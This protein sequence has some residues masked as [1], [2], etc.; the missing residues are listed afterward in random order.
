[1]PF[2]PCAVASM[3]DKLKSAE[4]V[5]K[6]DL[7]SEH[8][9][10]TFKPGFGGPFL[11]DQR[12]DLTGWY[13]PDEGYFWIMQTLVSTPEGSD[14]DGLPS[15]MA[16]GSNNHM[17]QFTVKLSGK[18]DED[19]FRTGGTGPGFEYSLPSSLTSLSPPDFFPNKCS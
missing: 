3:Q 1:M 7:A 10:G 16:N 18:R 17:L 8:F 2:A 9:S 6:R 19:Y 14:S 13:P 4:N 15:Y 12:L 11:R 5:I